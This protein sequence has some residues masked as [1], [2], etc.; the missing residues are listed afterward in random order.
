MCLHELFHS[1]LRSCVNL[2]RS[3]MQTLAQWWDIFAGEWQFGQASFSKTIASKQ[4]LWSRTHTHTHKI[5][6]IL[7][8]VY[9]I[10]IWGIIAYHVCSYSAYLILSMEKEIAKLC[11]HYQLTMVPILLLSHWSVLKFKSPCCTVQAT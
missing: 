4:E 11:C 10:I 8:C 7:Y 3:L 1:W 9:R 6:Y 2:K 5:H